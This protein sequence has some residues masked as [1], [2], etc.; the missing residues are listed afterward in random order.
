[1]LEVHDWTQTGLTF[2]DVVCRDIGGRLRW[3]RRRG[4]E[5]HGSLA[6][7]LASTQFGLEDV[8][9]VEATSPTSPARGAWRRARGSSGLGGGWLWL[10]V[11]YVGKTAELE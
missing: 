3:W 8:I 1:M 2:L 10:L 5:I 9:G 6:G 11:C 4:W 7:V